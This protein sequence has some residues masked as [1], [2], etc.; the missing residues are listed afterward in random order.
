MSAVLH[1]VG[2]V[3][4][5]RPTWWRSKRLGAPS[6]TSKLCV[7]LLSTTLDSTPSIC[8]FD[9]SIFSTTWGFCFSL[10][11]SL[12]NRILQQ[13]CKR[14]ELYTS[15]WH[16]RRVEDA[17]RVLL[18]SYGNIAPAQL[19]LLEGFLSSTARRVRIVL[20]GMIATRGFVRPTHFSRVRL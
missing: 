13:I 5:L 6:V 16:Q 14:G 1:C 8:S 15:F 4:A 2:F 20:A 3:P 9:F 10:K 19:N 12:P 18:A 17:V 7:C 11:A